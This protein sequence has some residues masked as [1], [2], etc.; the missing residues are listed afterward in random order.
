QLDESPDN[1]YFVGFRIDDEWVR[2]QL[3][4]ERANLG[5]GSTAAPLAAWFVV[6][7]NVVAR[8]SSDPADAHVRAF[9]A[10]IATRPSARLPP[11]TGATATTGALS[12]AD[13][14]EFDVAGERFLG[15]SFS[16]DPANP[17]AGRLILA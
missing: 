1:A 12:S 15:Q 4:A 16:L 11:S 14:I 6:G 5:A 9:R 8:A 10:D 3:L 17:Q 2:Q 13:H 7:G